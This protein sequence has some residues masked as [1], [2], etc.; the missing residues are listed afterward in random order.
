MTVDEA[1]QLVNAVGFLLFVALLG[2]AVVR[3]TIRIVF[4][5]IAG[6]EANIILRR[7]LTLLGSLL[8]V[9]GTAAAIRFFGWSDAFAGG[10]P[11]LLY[12]TANDLIALGALGYWVWAEYFVIGRPNKEND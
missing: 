11:R 2:L 1:I 8:V 5:R 4:Y 10:W 7:D 6:R 12:L 9:F 3:M